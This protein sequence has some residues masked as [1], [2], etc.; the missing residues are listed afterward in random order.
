VGSDGG[1]GRGAADEALSGTA[2]PAVSSVIID[3]VPAL[4]SERWRGATLVATV[5]A[6]LLVVVLS[7]WLH[8]AGR[9]SFDTWALRRSTA[10]IGTGGAHALSWIS[11]PVLSLSVIALIGVL[12][13]VGRRWRLVVLVAVAPALAVVLTEYVLKPLVDRYLFAPGVPIAVLRSYGGAF[14][15]GHETGVV[16]AAVLALVALGQLRLSG[17]ARAA[18]VAVLTGWTALGALGLVRNYYHYATDTIGAL[19]VAAAVVLGSALTIDA[20]VPALA[21]RPQLT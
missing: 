18:V 2:A 1:L 12:A 21:R 13:A 7:G 14:P 17:A 8:G 6:A 20:A 10:A 16:A 5:G 9:T 4:I 15:S 3:G 19:G 11:K